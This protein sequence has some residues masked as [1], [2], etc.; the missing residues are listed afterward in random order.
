MIGAAV[1]LAG[2]AA[3]RMA[4]LDKPG[5]VVG[6]STLLETVIAVVGDVPVVVVGRERKLSRAV[7]F[8]RESPAGGGPAAALAAG[9][10]AL[11]VAGVAPHTVALLASDLPGIVPETLMALDWALQ[12]DLAAPGVIGLDD[13]LRPQWL[14]GVWR[15]HSL[16]EA[17]EA[18]GD[19]TG[20]P[21]RSVLDLPGVLRLQLSASET[22][23]IDTPGDLDRWC[24]GTS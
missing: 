2:G 17:C 12:S 19:V 20:R 15:L 21:L 3:S 5:L 13:D 18:A 8:A 23:D 16:R 4:G 6:G 11:D 10:A 14:L 9:L 22:M 1:V 7:I 24:R